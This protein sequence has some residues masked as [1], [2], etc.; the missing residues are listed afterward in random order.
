MPDR[1]GSDRNC[2]SFRSCVSG[3]R[4]G[5]RWPAHPGAAMVVRRSRTLG[6][7]DVS[8]AA[9][10]RCRSSER[11]RNRWMTSSSASSSPAWLV[12]NAV[13]RVPSMSVMR[14]CAPTPRW[15]RHCPDAAPSPADLRSP[16]GRILLVLA[17]RGDQ[18]GVQVHDQRFPGSG[19]ARRGVGSGG[20]PEPGAGFGAGRVGRVA[21]LRRPGRSL[22]WAETSPDLKRSSPDRGSRTAC[23]TVRTQ[24]SGPLAGPP[25]SRFRPAGRPRPGAR[26]RPHARR[27]RVRDGNG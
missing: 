6:I 27:S 4:D 5:L 19:G 11:I 12:A 8:G 23:A 1:L 10:A 2:H 21:G 14:G 26:S 15:C 3:C 7:K 22:R 25:L 18:C 17:R 20:F 16:R 24:C 9:A 13:W